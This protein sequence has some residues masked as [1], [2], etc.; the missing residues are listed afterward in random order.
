[1]SDGIP[2]STPPDPA[3]ELALLVQRCKLGDAEAF[4]DLCERYR[5]RLLR[6]ART[7]MSEKGHSR[8]P[9][10]D[11]VQDA[12]L[13][14]SQKLPELDYR[15]LHAF[16]A[17]MLQIC[18]GKIRD[19]IRHLGAAKR[20]IGRERA[21]IDGD[22]KGVAADTPGAEVCGTPSRIAYRGEKGSI[23]DELLDKLS[24]R[25]AAVLRLRHLKGM[26]FGEIGSHMEI[27]E[28]AAKALYGRA[29][30]RFKSIAGRHPGVS[31]FTEVMGPGQD[32]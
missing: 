22:E 31:D 11:I 5:D 17:W 12:L 15:G 20:D 28:D 1:M 2:G 32:P 18:D 30:K 24:D 19:W 25:H 23:V 9:P 3:I 7:H 27:S 29:A 8:G 6:Y 4:Q 21:L 10:D 14:I 13:T 16:E 26:A